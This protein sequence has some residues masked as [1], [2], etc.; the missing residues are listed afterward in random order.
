MLGS[1]VKLT[2]EELE[3]LTKEQLIDLCLS[4]HKTQKDLFDRLFECDYEKFLEVKTF[5]KFMKDFN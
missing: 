1:L 5:Y 4:I 3:K 2:K